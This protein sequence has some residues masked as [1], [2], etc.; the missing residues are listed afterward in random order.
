MYSIVLMM[1]LTTGGDSPAFCRGGCC[2]GGCC[3][4]CACCGGGRGCRGCR[5]CCGGCCGGYGYCCGGYGCGGYGCGG[6][7]GCAGYGGMIIAP[8]AP[9]APA[10]DAPKKAEASPATI[11]VTLPAEAKLSIDGAATTS[12][13]ESRVFTTPALPSGQQLFYTFKAEMVRDGQTVTTTKQVPV[14]AGEET[15]V[16][17]EFPVASVAS[18]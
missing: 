10:G 4:G 15:R 11:N 16:S 17:L 12:T 9:A 7:I 1:A 13:G 2:G 8:A 5:G 3:G 6:Y 14:R 18:K